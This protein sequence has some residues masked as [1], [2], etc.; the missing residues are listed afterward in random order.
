MKLKKIK[1]LLVCLSSLMVVKFSHSQLIIEDESKLNE[2]ISNNFES[3][4][5]NK[6]EDEVKSNQVRVKVKKIELIEIKNDRNSIGLNLIINTEIQS[7]ENSQIFIGP[8]Y[9]QLILKEHFIWPKFEEK[10]FVKI[11]NENVS[12]TILG[13]QFDKETVRVRIVFDE[14]EKLDFLNNINPVLKRLDNQVMLNFE[15]NALYFN[16]SNSTNEDGKN[17]I[18]KIKG[19]VDPL[20]SKNDSLKKYQGI[21]KNLIVKEKIKNES[22]KFSSNSRNDFKTYLI[23]YVVVLIAII[24]IFI[25]LVQL[26][27][28]GILEKTK[29]SFLSSKS[30]INVMTQV[31][32]APKK[33]LM[34]V[35][36]QDQIFLLSNA[37][38][39]I[40]FI[41]E[42][43]NPQLAIKETEL[44]ITGENFDSGL[45]KAENDPKIES[46]VKLK[47]ERYSE[48]LNEDEINLTRVSQIKKIKN[49]ENYERVSFSDQLKGKLKGLKSF[50]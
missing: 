12:L 35:K 31:Y 45:I 36:I 50:N 11:N 23:K 20:I 9:I 47:N 46:K 14:F 26:F 41:S 8:N 24:S 17:D 1:N 33:S 49:N 48:M 6:N 27:K 43:K 7:K 37:E 5:L 34:L 3:I 30:L 38:N 42:I 21:E 4:N 25:L 28:K 22:N 29:L 15:I 39:G 16:R 19:I 13:Y 10:R 40:S 2:S 44:N 18:E 32:V